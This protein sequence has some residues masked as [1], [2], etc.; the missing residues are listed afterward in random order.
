[1]KN[2]KIARE[3]QLIKTCAKQQL[4]NILAKIKAVEDPSEKNL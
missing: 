1:M 2:L 4:K 3:K